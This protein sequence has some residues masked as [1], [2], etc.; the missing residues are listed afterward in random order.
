MITKPQDRHF[1][2]QLCIELLIFDGRREVDIALHRH[3]DEPTASAW[4]GQGR[5]LV[6]GADERGIAAVAG[7]GLAVGRA[8]FQVGGR[9]EVFQDNLLPLGDLVELVEVDEGEAG[10]AEVQVALVL[11]VDAV[12]VVLALLSW[13]QDATK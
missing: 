10:Q 4:V 8:V 6:G 9:H 3:A 5:A 12:V 13:Q 7:V 2:L 11:E 1:V